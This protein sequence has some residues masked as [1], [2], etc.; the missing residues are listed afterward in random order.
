MFGTQAGLLGCV[1]CP[2]GTHSKQWDLSC[3]ECPNGTYSRQIWDPLARMLRGAA[4]CTA[5][6]AETPYTYSTGAIDASACRVCPEHH[7]HNESGCFLCRTRC[8][9]AEVTVS[10]CSDHSDLMCLP[11]S[12]SCGTGFYTTPC[13]SRTEPEMCLECTNKPEHSTYEDIANWYNTSRWY[14]IIGNTCPWTCDSGYYA[15]GDTSM[16]L[17]CTQYD[18]LSCPPG[19]VLTPCNA[20]RLVNL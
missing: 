10:E 19:R 11:C 9:S 2:N 6:S 12:L 7:F 16:C 14:N 3:T 1:A 17:P 15:S 5:C 13:N 8:D 4:V 18:L 20:E